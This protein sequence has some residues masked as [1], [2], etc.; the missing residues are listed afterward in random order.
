MDLQPLGQVQESFI[1][2]ANSDGLWIVDQHA[3]HERVL[4]DRHVRMRQEK[5]VAVQR[6]LC[7][8]FWN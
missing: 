8:S 1:V 6:L 5:K 2:A 3:A 4:F 7:R